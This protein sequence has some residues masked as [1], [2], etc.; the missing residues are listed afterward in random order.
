MKLRLMFL[1]IIVVT[2]VAGCGAN[3]TPSPTMEPQVDR[4]S[5]LGEPFTLH[6]S[7]SAFL[8]AGGQ[9]YLLDF[10]KVLADSRCPVGI[11]CLRPDAAIIEVTLSGPG[12]GSGTESYQ[13]FFDSGP[14]EGIVGPFT[15]QI[16]AITPDVEHVMSPSDYAIHL[17]VRA[18][19]VEANIDV[20]MTSSASIAVVGDRVT[21]TVSAAG[22]A[23]A[24]YT[25]SVNGVIV[26]IMQH[27]G[28]LTRDSQTPVIE[29][30]DWSADA[31]NASWTID[32]L[33]A[34]TFVMEA[35]IV[36]RNGGY[37]GSG[38][39]AG[40]ARAELTVAEE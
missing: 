23:H 24:Q 39:V 9:P 21:Y 26:G 37:Q 3:M 14:S 2:S 11:E 30:L 5:T 7:N 15:V 40:D 17:V 18:S 34:G 13:L 38:S 1:T 16:L 19:P 32:V 22:L 28:T 35:S 20:Q 12:F 6:P 33:T 36:A 4:P 10:K 27:D 8:E 25:L 29:L 31:S